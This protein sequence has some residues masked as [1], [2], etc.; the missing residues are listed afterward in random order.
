MKSFQEAYKNLGSV[1]WTPGCDEL[2]FLFNRVRAKQP[3]HILEIGTGGGGST[4][5]MHEAWPQADII[6][7][8][9]DKVLCWPEKPEVGFVAKARIPE[10]K[11]TFVTSPLGRVLLNNVDFIFIDGNHHAPFPTLD[12]IYALPWCSVTC[13]LA[14]HD[15]GLAAKCGTDYQY[16]VGADDL[17]SALL[18]F[19]G[20][21]EKVDCMA[22]CS[23]QVDNP[24]MLAAF[25]LNHLISFHK[26][27]NIPYGVF[28]QAAV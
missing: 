12:L 6:T 2:G 28:R 15:V 22:I 20:N 13:E 3:K 1:L 9:V 14:L 11:V 26:E 8:D 24:Y 7:L 4:Y 5:I 25:V 23:L 17:W 18:R 19:A 10:D 27:T 16:D 21:M